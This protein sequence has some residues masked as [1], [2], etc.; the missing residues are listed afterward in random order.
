MPRITAACLALCLFALA[1][2]GTKPETAETAEA[3]PQAQRPTLVYY[4]IGTPDRDLSYVNQ[5]L[6]AL[7]EDEI[8]ATIDYRKIG[9]GEYEGSLNMLIESGQDFDIMFALNYAQYAKRNVLLDL[10]PYFVQGAIGRGMY[11]TIDATF[12]EGVTLSGKIYGVPTNK[13]LAVVEQWMYAKELIDK[14]NIDITRYHTL[15][16]LEPLFEMIA[17]Q[18]PEYQ[19]MRMDKESNNLFQPYG[20]EYISTRRLPL[21]VKSLAQS[22]EIVNPFETEVG[23]Q[24]LQTLRQYYLQGYINEDAG[25]IP[26]ASLSPNKKVFFSMGSGGP[27]SAPIWS[28][29]RKY[30]VVAEMVTNPVVTTE[31]TQAGVMSVNVN[32]KYPQACVAFLSL[33]NTDPKV[34]NLLAYGVEGVHYSL[35]DNNQVVISDTEGYTGVQYTQGNWFILHTLGG[36]EP[37]PL[38]KWEKYKEYNSAAVKS[39]ILGFIPDFSDLEVQ[40]KAVAEVWDIYYPALMTGSVDVEEY[41]PKFNRLLHDAGLDEIKKRLQSQLEDW[42]SV[43]NK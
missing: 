26:S 43:K 30:P 41:L 18:E 14:Y 34:R 21:M 4:T 3:V 6:N 12:W 37:E 8:N 33:I 1:A 7:V 20:Y 11:E 32:T 38:D 22:P 16:S 42:L 31:S 28:M 40:K 36:A 13:E 5:Q 29:Q 10:S 27:Y 39:N 17:G 35:D 19:I 15:A 25:L 24:I 23:K 2:C 9:W